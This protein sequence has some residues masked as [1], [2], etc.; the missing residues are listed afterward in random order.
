VHARHRPPVEGGARSPPTPS[1]PQV[2]LYQ[3]ANADDARSRFTWLSL[4]GPALAPLPPPGSPGRA[5]CTERLGA[6]AALRPV[7]DALSGWA[8]GGRVRAALSHLHEGALHGTATGL[9]LTLNSKSHTELLERMGAA[10]GCSL[11]C[12]NSYFQVDLIGG[13]EDSHTVAM[14]NPLTLCLQVHS[15]TSK[16]EVLNSVSRR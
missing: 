7:L 12:V 10:G 6:D 16:V 2:T 11:V 3:R 1:T 5:G 14:T 8:R 13:I 4:G 9:H 15:R